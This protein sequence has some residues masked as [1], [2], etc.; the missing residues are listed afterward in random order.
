MECIIIK[1]TSVDETVV[2]TNLI[3]QIKNNIRVNTIHDFAFLLVLSDS[4]KDK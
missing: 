2:F 1:Y 3:E 4:Q